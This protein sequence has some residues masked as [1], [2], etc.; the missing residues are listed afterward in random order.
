MENSRFP[1]LGDDSNAGFIITDS[2]NNGTSRRVKFIEL[3]GSGGSCFAYRGELQRSDGSIKSIVI[4]EYFPD[5]EISKDFVRHNYGEPAYYIGKNNL[6]DDSTERNVFFKRECEIMREIHG[7]GRN[8][9]PFAFDSE[10]IMRPTE[11]IYNGE[12]H[13]A[14]PNVTS[15]LLIDTNAGMT[16]KKKIRDEKIS[17]LDAIKLTRKLLVVVDHLNRV[18]GCSH[19]DIKPE[20]I[21]IN[22]YE[23]G[24]ADDNASITLLDFGSVFKYKDYQ[25]DEEELEEMTP[26][27]L[28]AAAQKIVDNEYIGLTTEGYQMSKI[29]DIHN[30]FIQFVDFPNMIQ[31]EELL[32]AVNEMGIDADLYSVMKVF[33]DMVLSL[34]RDVK[35]WEGIQEVTGEDRV[36][37]EF[38]DKIFR[39]TAVYVYRTVEDVKKDLDILE[40]LCN[41]KIH[42]E[43]A[44]MADFF[45]LSNDDMDPTLFGKYEH[46]IEE[47]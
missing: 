6:E 15:Y 44:F 27:E 7:V 5:S 12:V 21:Y 25:I 11:Y 37:C 41:K 4:K 23:D 47:K 46:V 16:L 24:I 30:A 18:C 33:Q 17:V 8:N 32:Q 9:N 31:A 1:I 22:D 2:S 40:T 35:G 34:R 38:L 13:Q 36:V 19:C 14:E 3:L 20:N 45:K 10:G 26:K 43:V 28:V 29:Q 39:N 42:P